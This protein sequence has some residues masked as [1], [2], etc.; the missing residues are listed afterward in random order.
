MIAAYAIG[1]HMAFWY[2]RGEFDLSERRMRAAV[3]TLYDAGWLGKNIQGTGFDLDFFVHRGAGAYICGEETGLISSLE[4]GKGQ[5]KLKPPFPAV[6]GA[7]ESPTIVNNVESLAAVPWI[8]N[9]GAAAYSQQ[10]TEKSRGTKLFSVSGPVK[11]PGVYEVPLGFPMR[12]LIDDLC[13]GMQDGKVMKA[14]IPGGSSTPVL[15]AEVAMGVS[16]D[17][18]A[19]A[20]AGTMLGSGGVIVIDD[21]Q[22]MPE[23]LAVLGRFYAHESCGQCTPCRE[24][25]GWASRLLTRI[26]DGEGTRH[27]LDTL[28]RITGF[29]RGTTI[30][31]LADALAMPIQSFFT[32][33]MDEFEAVIKPV[34]AVGEVS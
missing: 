34:Q 30:C 16:L 11:R 22:S 29:L 8:L 2:I 14:I 7:F 31:P 28:K 4:G 24:G 21:T 13:G 17:Y 18:E 12:D 23:L 1:S 32:H 10:G 20:E 33:F 27:D 9:N 26:A 6:K 19:M 3:K 25:T 15:P 5:P